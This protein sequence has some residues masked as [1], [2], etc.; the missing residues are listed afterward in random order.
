[1]SEENENPGYDPEEDVVAICSECKTEQDPRR[2]E[3]DMWLEAGMP[4]VCKSCGGVV[5]LTLREDVD[6]A[7]NQS[8]RR[9]GIG[10][11]VHRKREY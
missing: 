10:A 11:P 2:M 9:R 6:A 1:M 7:L 5:I 3:K 4:A 8:D